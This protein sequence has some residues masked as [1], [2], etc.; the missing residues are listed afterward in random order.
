[1]YDPG[2]PDLL[3][4]ATLQDTVLAGQNTPLSLEVVLKAPSPDGTYPPLYLD[5]SPLGGTAQVP[6]Q[7]QEQ[8]RYTA[9]TE[10]SPVQTG[11]FHLPVWL[12]PEGSPPVL[13]YTVTLTVL[14]GEDLVLFGDGP[15]AGWKW[16]AGKGTTLDPAAPAPVFQG[17]KA[18]AL[19]AS[20]QGAVSCSATGAPVSSSGYDSL[21]LYVHPGEV[22]PV[23]FSVGLKGWDTVYLKKRVDWTKQS[24]QK[25]AIPLDSLYGV[26]AMY[27]IPGEAIPSITFFLGGSLYLDDIRL[28]AARPSSEPNTAVLEEQAASLPQRCSLS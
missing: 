18:L 2:R 23:S 27:L 17:E 24:W 25:V 8:G 7:H 13:L 11:L 9:E 14:P 3:Q 1:M 16:E 15:G 19:Q 26:T 28:V 22:P 12:A 5:L 21:C 10:I 4:Q 20:S 6:L